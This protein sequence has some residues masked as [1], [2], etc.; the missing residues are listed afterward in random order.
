MT[1]RFGA[2]LALL[3]VLAGAGASAGQAKPGPAAPAKMDPSDAFFA[4][5]VI[6]QLRIKLSPQAE[7]SLRA[8][9]RKFVEGALVEDGTTTYENVRVKLKGAAGSFRPYDNLPAFTIRIAKGKPE[10]HGLEKF[11]L[12]NSVQDESYM[13]E[14]LCSQLSREA[15][16][17]AA[18]ATHARVWVNDRHLGFYGLKEGFDEEFLKRN[19][20]AAKGKGNLYDGGFLQDID[21]PL[22]RDE[23]DGPDDKADLKALLEA[24]REPD[25]A[26]RRGLIAERLDVEAFLNFV[27][28]E[29]MMC[30]WDGYARNKNNYRIYFRPDTKKAVFLPHGMDQMFGDTNFPVFEV[31]GTI[32]SSAVLQNPEWG[33]KY[34]KRVRELIPSFAPDKLHA[35]V[36]AAA[37][38]VRAVL[39]AMDANRARHVDG[40]I[41]EFRARLN[42]RQKSIRAQLPPEP[43]SFGKQNWAPI[44][45]W[46]PA[47]EGDAKLEKK[48]I[49]GRPLLM[50]ETGPSRT[51]T[52][53]FRTKV[54]LTKGIYK[55][56]AKVRTVN[57]K[58]I[59]DGKGLGAGL[60][61]DGLDRQNTNALAGTSEWRTLAYPFQ[62]L[63]DAKDVE[64]IAELRGTA[65]VVAFDAAS[66]KL[67]KVR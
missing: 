37:A 20:P 44:G 9:P 50:I 4:K 12:N 61:I 63:E 17:P 52:A 25:A 42:D 34:R 23:G 27:A 33:G 24:C 58:G 46:E 67:V 39:T 64:L 54:R 41:Q 40:R 56:E 51:C 62:V 43:I 19:F 53:S 30:H 57:V 2:G 31:P 29:L 15:G 45:D 18:R 35:K 60:R 22:E 5:G 65:G 48:E 21:A 16:L 14:L 11:H 49:S 36:D 66:F 10:F 7:A 38:R 3:A 6:P 32:V 26:R 1:R 28:L 47:P 8:E 59:S 55:L 13:S